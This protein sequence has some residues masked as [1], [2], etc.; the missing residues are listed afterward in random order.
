MHAI[1][2][3]IVKCG[4]ALSQQTKTEVTKATTKLNDSKSNN[5]D[6]PK[7]YTVSKRFNSGNNISRSC[8]KTDYDC[9]PIRE[10]VNIYVMIPDHDTSGH[11]RTD[12]DRSGHLSPF[13]IGCLVHSRG[14]P[15]LMS[16]WFMVSVENQSECCRVFSCTGRRAS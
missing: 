11:I 5:T 10:S 4:L 6:I 12:P 2:A 9:N 13:L 15:K 1:L 7:M 16:D 8:S 14:G 3:G